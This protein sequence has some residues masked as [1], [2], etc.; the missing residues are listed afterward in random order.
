VQYF[1]R[2]RM[3]YHGNGLILLGA[4]VRDELHEVGWMG[5]GSAIETDYRTPTRRQF[6]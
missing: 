6:E 1:E 3:E 2:V 5:P 4:L